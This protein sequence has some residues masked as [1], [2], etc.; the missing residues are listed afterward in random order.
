[1]L[2]HSEVILTWPLPVVTKQRKALKKIL[3]WQTAANI[4]PW[5]AE[6]NTEIN[7]GTPATALAA[8]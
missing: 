4:R 2:Q 7:F 3:Q 5:K 6:L 8:C 1:M